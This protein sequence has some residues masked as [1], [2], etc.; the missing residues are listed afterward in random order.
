[1]SCSAVAPLG[2]VSAFSRA[3]R[4]GRRHSEVE[5]S[6][7]AARMAA[8]LVPSMRAR[9]RPSFC[10]RATSCFSGGR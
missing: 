5:A 8:G 3:S 10:A 6:F 2:Y 7:A 4:L 9:A 1:M